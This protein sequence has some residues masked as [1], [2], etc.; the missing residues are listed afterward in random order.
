MQEQSKKLNQL[1]DDVNKTINEALF[2]NP[3]AKKEEPMGPVFEDD[4]IVINRSLSLLFKQTG[5]IIQN[6]LPNYGVWVEIDWSNPEFNWLSIAE[7]KASSAEIEGK[8]DSRKI[9]K[10]KQTAKPMAMI[11]IKTRM[12]PGRMRKIKSWWKTSLQTKI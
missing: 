8:G 12:K 10:I 4:V 9:S 3:F 2:K 7:F 11:R 1:M 5:S 6:P